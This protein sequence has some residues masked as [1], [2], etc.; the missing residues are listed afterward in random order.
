MGREKTEKRQ[1]MRR[2]DREDRGREEKKIREE[3]VISFISF[4]LYSLY[5][6][7]SLSE[8]YYANNEILSNNKV[9]E[10][11]KQAGRPSFPN[12][13]VTWAGM[14]G[15][16]RNPMQP[17]VRFPVRSDNGPVNSTCYSL[18]TTLDLLFLQIYSTTW[19]VSFLALDPLS[20]SSLQNPHLT[21]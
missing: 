4:T 20:A 2:Q 5:Y 11:T 16:W 9:N 15:L 13:L 10:I 6:L 18:L 8:D 17:A 21:K 14:E 3:A 7:Q 12:G 1:K 19:G